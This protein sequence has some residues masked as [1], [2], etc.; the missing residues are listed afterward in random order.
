VE[1]HTGKYSP[2]A[3]TTGTTAKYT[4]SNSVSTASATQDPEPSRRANPSPRC[5]RTT[6]P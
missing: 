3:T 2:T 5:A 1:Y 4:T 6:A